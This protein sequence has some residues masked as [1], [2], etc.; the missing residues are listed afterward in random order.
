MSAEL[1]TL[2]QAARRLARSLGWPGGRSAEK[3]LRR[4]IEAAEARKRREIMVRSTTASGHTRHKVAMG[5][6]RRYCPELFESG[7]D[8]FAREFR[9]MLQSIDDRIEGEVA[10]QIEV[11]VTPKLTQIEREMVIHRE[12]LRELGARVK[13]VAGRAT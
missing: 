11:R 4:H 3:R 12:A 6:L 8:A 9:R 10:E 5:A 13:R 7:A 1:L 2:P